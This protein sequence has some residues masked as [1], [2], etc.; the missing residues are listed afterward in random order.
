[1]VFVWK[2]DWSF[3]GQTDLSQKSATTEALRKERLFHER[4]RRVWV[5]DQFLS[6]SGNDNQAPQ[7]SCTE[8]SVVDWS[9]Q[10]ADNHSTFQWTGEKKISFRSIENERDI[11]LK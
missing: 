6:W 4:C 1:M 2:G 5:N 8:G 9:V 10:T 3:A 7:Y 11:F